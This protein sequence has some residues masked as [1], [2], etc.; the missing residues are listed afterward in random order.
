MFMKKDKSE[1][2]KE[3]ALFDRK[4]KEIAGNMDQL[5]EAGRPEYLEFIEYLQ[6]RLLR[7]MNRLLLKQ[8]AV[9]DD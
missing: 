6:A 3:I 7:S 2:C 5:I 9:D 4:C 8:Y 1:I